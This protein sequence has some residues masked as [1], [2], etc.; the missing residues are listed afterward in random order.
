LNPTEA[1]E[2]LDDTVEE[3][4]EILDNKFG[5]GLDTGQIEMLREASA[6]LLQVRKELHEF[7]LPDDY[8]ECLHEE[9]QQ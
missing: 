9:E 8:D 6:R 2:I 4:Q 5:V 7:D 3:V 1:I